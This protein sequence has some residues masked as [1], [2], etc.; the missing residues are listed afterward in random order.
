MSATADN[1]ADW[2]PAFAE[3]VQ[4]YSKYIHTTRLPKDDQA[5]QLKQQLSVIQSSDLAKVSDTNQQLYAAFVDDLFLP[6][7]H[8]RR[9][10]GFKTGA[11]DSVDTTSVGVLEANRA[12]LT[13]L[14]PSYHTI[15]YIM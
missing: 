4:H 7:S 3:L 12:W 10:L 8:V 13:I 2:D 9:S 1:E 14:C 11:D 15:T 5:I 6:Q